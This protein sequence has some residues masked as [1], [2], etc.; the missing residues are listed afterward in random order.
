MVGAEFRVPEL[1][2]LRTC[3]NELGQWLGD[4]TVGNKHIISARG[5]T[6]ILS[7]RA[8]GIVGRLDLVEIVLVELADKASKVRVLEVLRQDRGRELVH[9]LCGK[10][11]KSATSARFVM[12]GG[13]LRTWTTNEVPSIPQLMIALRFPSSKILRRSNGSQTRDRTGEW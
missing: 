11:W 7:V 2:D 8:R 12:S 4:A 1:P 5:T 6:H 9:V 13:G 3:P 10:P